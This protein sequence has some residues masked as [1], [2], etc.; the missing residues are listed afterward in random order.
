MDS[1]GDVCYFGDKKLGVSNSV[2]LDPS[3]LA[4][5]ISTIITREDS[6][7]LEQGILYH[8]QCKKVWANYPSSLHAM[9]IALFNK[10]EIAYT[11]PEGDP[12]KGPYSI[13]PGMLPR[14][15]GCCLSIGKRVEE[16]KTWRI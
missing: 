10:L 5:L 9:L 4:D 14:C 1:L 8:S 2:V 12:E 15:V 16:S 11:T 13:I 6:G 7:H 3:F